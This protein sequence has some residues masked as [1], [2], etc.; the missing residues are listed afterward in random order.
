MKVEKNYCETAACIFSK[1][2]PTFWKILRKY[3]YDEE[4]LAY[5]FEVI[6]E[7]IANFGA[8]SLETISYCIDFQASYREHQTSIVK[9]CENLNKLA[10][11]E[12]ILSTAF[13]N[14]IIQIIDNRFIQYGKIVYPIEMMTPDVFNQDSISYCLSELNFSRRLSHYYIMLY[15]FDLTMKMQKIKSEIIKYELARY[16]KQCGKAID[17]I[18]NENLSYYM[19]LNIEFIKYNSILKKFNYYGPLVGLFPKIGN[20]F[21]PT[22]NHLLCIYYNKQFDFD[23]NRIIHPTCKDRNKFRNAR[24]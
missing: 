7:N 11:Y 13:H 6:S 20:I 14:S 19:D 9:Y 12:E 21:C 24:H 5:I 16:G 8:Q 4:E 18:I 17:I 3:N 2:H 15:V 23:N 1:K 22:N 10:K